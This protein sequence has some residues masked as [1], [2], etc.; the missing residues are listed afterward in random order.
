MTS[1][2]ERVLELIQYRIDRRV[3]SVL[4]VEDGDF[5]VSSPVSVPSIASVWR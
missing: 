5:Q 3:E 1:L 2:Q 4:A